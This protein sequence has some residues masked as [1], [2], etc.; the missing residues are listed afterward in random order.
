MIKHYFFLYQYDGISI[1]M[2]ASV[3][4]KNHSNGDKEKHSF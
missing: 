1:I 4:K 3:K 2:N